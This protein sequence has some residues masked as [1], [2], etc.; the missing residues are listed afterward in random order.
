MGI[1]IRAAGPPQSIGDP[2]PILVELKCDGASGMFC[3]SIE[4][5]TDKAGYTGCHAAAMT[6]GWLERQ[7]PQGRLWLCPACSGKLT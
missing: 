1:I 5:F 2:I 7:S 6:R 4:T 3:W